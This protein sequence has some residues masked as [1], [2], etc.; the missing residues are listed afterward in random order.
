MD[1]LNTLFPATT[2][3]LP[4]YMRNDGELGNENV[5][6]GD[7]AVPRLSLLQ[8]MS[9]QCQVAL[10]GCLPGKL[11]NTVSEKVADFVYVVNLYMT[12]EWT[13]FKKMSE[14]GGVFGS[15]GNEA[16][17]QAHVDTLP[18]DPK[19]YEIFEVHRHTV[20]VLNEQGEVD[21]PA[22]ILMKSTN[23]KPYREWT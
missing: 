7:I 11:Y 23:L 17:A 3:A 20:L 2:D 4:A 8:S 13:I 14:G 16:T 6:A 12:K 19:I 5:G 18:G 9:P 22:E 10:P 1:D 21:S 15:F